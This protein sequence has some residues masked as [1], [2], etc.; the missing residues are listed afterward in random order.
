LLVGFVL[1]A[2]QGLPALLSVRL[3][4]LGFTKACGRQASHKDVGI[5]VAG[6]E[7]LKSR[8]LGLVVMPG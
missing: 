7:Y 6:L 5:W 2:Y 4:K 3:G 8:S 1:K